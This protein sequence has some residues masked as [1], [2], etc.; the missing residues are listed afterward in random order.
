MRQLM[1]PCVAY[2]R[3]R[4]GSAL[5]QEMHGLSTIRRQDIT[6]YG[7]S[8]GRRQDIIWTNADLLLIG[9]LGSEIRI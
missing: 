3:Q 9:P 2:M 6:W 8:T 4:I 5:V 1:P 7:L